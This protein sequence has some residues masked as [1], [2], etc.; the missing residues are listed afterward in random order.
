M[1]IHQF[2]P[3]TVHPLR[4]P[5]KTEDGDSGS[6]GNFYRRSHR[7]QDQTEDSEGQD[8]VPSL[9]STSKFIDIRV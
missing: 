5:S 1:E 3:S 8:T 2:P 9:K 4:A 6:S 7:H